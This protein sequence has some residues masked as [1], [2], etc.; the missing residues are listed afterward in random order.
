MP[1]KA[2]A[3]RYNPGRGMEQLGKLHKGAARTDEDIQKKRPGRD[4]NYFRVEFQQ[5]LAPEYRQLFD[6]MYGSQAYEIPNVRLIAPTPEG[7]LSWWNEEWGT[8]GLY[9]R[10]DGEHQEAWFDRSQGK[11]IYDDPAPCVQG[12]GKGCQC[13]PVGRINLFLPDFCYASGLWGYFTL[14]THSTKDLTYLHAVLTDTYG[15]VG[16]LV[17]LP[18]ILS[19]AEEEISQPEIDRNTRKPTG[20]RIHI[21][22]S[23][24][25]LRLMDAPTRLIAGRLSGMAA[26]EGGQ[27]QPALPALTAPEGDRWDAGQAKDW[28][29]AIQKDTGMTGAEILDALGVASLGEWQGDAV[30]ATQRIKRYID[31]EVQKELEGKR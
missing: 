17:N 1:I 5:G 2:L 15:M 30:S 24:I 19:R 6:Q 26:L 27:P 9:H 21:K 25:R 18:F 12:Q 3:N 23:L 8:G 10:C 31:Q 13:K 20:N 14:L 11:V 7:A 16:T 4:L 22:K 28:A 29:T